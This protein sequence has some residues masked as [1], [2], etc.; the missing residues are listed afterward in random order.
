MIDWMQYLAQQAVDGS[1]TQSTTTQPAPG[2]EEQAEPQ[3]LFGSG[4]TMF[5]MMG[6]LFVV[7]YFLMI[8]PQRKEE[9]RKQE[10][11]ASLKKGDQVVT[12][13]GIIGSVAQVKDDTVT[14]NVGNGSKIEFL[15]SAIGNM[16]GADS[17]KGDSAEKADKKK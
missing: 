6:L 11:M 10:M 7:M 1:D 14:L 5:I 15:R 4:S 13:S 17:K 8:R 12:T 3:G 9:K 16:R 2:A